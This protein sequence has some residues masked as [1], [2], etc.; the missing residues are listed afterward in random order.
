MQEE[1]A[2]ELEHVVRGARF[3]T[4]MS[5]CICNVAAVLE[6]LGVVVRA[7]VVASRALVQS[8]MRPCTAK[9]RSC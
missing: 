8:A 7:G 2:S 3:S 1:V 5:D 4:V 6:E 9:G